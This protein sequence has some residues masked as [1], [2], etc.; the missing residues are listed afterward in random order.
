MPDTFARKASV[1]STALGHL[2][3]GLLINFGEAH[4]KDGIRRIINGTLE[5]DE[6]AEFSL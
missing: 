3:L 1:D 5:A 2:K 4:F 6:S